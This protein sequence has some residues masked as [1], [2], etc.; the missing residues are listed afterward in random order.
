MLDS[1]GIYSVRVR[2]IVEVDHPSYRY[3]VPR[4]GRRGTSVARNDI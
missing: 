4:H 3:E 2:M 1:M